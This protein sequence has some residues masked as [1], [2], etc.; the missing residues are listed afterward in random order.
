[1]DVKEKMHLFRGF[2]PVYGFASSPCFWYNRKSGY[3]MELLYINTEEADDD[4]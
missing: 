2:E 1:M 3:Y 4:I